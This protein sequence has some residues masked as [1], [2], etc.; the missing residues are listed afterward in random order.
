MTETKSWMPEKTKGFCDFHENIFFIYGIPKIG[1]TTLASKFPDALFF[2]TEDGCKHVAVSS[3]RIRN[4]LEFC[5]KV[6]V[7]EEHIKDSPFRTVIIDTVDN[8]FTLCDEH[9]CKQNNLRVLGDLDYGKG[10]GYYTKEFKKQLNRITNLGLGL[11]FVSHASEKEVQIEAVTNPYA[12]MMGDLETGKVKMIVPTLEKRS[13]LFLLGLSD[14]IFY[15]ELD[16]S[17]NRVIRTQPTKHFEAGDRSGRLAP[18]LP[19]DYN[20]LLES[21]Y[22][23]GNGSG[24]SKDDTAKQALIGRIKKAFVYLAENQID[25][26]EVPT[27]VD[28]SV[29]KN[30]EVENLEDATI[31][32]LQSYLQHL[33]MIAKNYKKEKV[34]NG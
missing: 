20:A 33:K 29:K 23:N 5:Q 14:M 15:L 3:W 22:G 12:P 24:E 4:W 7:L 26:F 34:S 10:Y 18:T 13:M 9:I 27:R 21:Y 25:G 11:V 28:N 30:L 32:K 8:L 16:R 17:N 6:G 2:Q 1:K 31:D 19:L